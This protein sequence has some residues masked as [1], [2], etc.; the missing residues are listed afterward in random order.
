MTFLRLGVNCA[1]LDDD[2]RILLSRR[3]DLNIWNLP[4]GRLDRGE[5]LAAAAVREVREETG[6]VAHLDQPVGLYYWAG[7]DRLNILYSGWVLGGELQQATHETRENTFF[8]LR[9][10]PDD[11]SW[12]WMLFDAISDVRPAPRVIETPPDELR[13]MKSRLRWRWV[14]NLLSGHPEPRY[15]RFTVRAVAVLWDEDHRRILT[16]PTGR[17]CVLPRVPCA[18]SQSPWGELSQRI[19]DLCGLRPDLQWVGLWQDVEQGELELVFAAS[20]EEGEPLDEAEWIT[21]RNAPLVELDSWYVNRVRKRY[22]Q[23]P[24]WVIQ[25][26]I[27][28]VDM[29]VIERDSEYDAG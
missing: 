24:V 6:V 9:A 3:G 7:W 11:L 29:L 28:E 25:N 4:G 8:D 16:L 27:A 13:R 22:M 5:P 23:D 17:Q 26:P 18:G 19:N 14:K 15:P 20:I 12:E 1:V 10:L 2:G 21:A